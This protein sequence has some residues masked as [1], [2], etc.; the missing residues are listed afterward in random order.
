MQRR[1]SISMALI[2]TTTKLIILDEPSTGLDPQTKRVIW[3]NIK[4]VA[5]EPRKS[6]MVT[7]ASMDK[8]K[9]YRTKE[10]LPGIILT[11][12]DMNELNTICDSIQIMSSG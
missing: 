10:T 12:H 9:I 4:R 7:G 2:N 5:R 1:V 8:A 6:V 11:S 3:A